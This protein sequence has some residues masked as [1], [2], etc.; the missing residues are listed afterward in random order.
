[1]YCSVQFPH[2]LNTLQSSS[3]SWVIILIP[4]CD[5]S[6]P[7]VWS[8]SSSCV[9]ILI[10]M[11]DHHHPYVWS[12]S[13]S[14]VII[15]I[16]MCDHPHPH[17]WSSSSSCVIII[18][19]FIFF[20]SLTWFSLLSILLSTDYPFI[21]PSTYEPSVIFMI[22]ICVWNAIITGI[23]IIILKHDRNIIISFHLPQYF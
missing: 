14:C 18:I 1:M 19:A 15:L 22:M 20:K 9:I 13:S 10:L 2:S 23:I 11:C 6:H 4:M 5:H 3:S 16:L 12:S 17:V 8:S 21:H 7:H